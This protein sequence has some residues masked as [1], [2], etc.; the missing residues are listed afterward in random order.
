MIEALK[1]GFGLIFLRGLLFGVVYVIRSLT[2]ELI[3]QD[4]IDTE[5]RELIAAN[6]A[7]AVSLARGNVER[8][9]WA[10]GNTD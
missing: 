3:H 9:Q 10:K 6:G 2:R 7:Q 5:A 4:E 8:S 1:L